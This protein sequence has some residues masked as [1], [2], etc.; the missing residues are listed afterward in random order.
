MEKNLTKTKAWKKLALHYRFF[1]DV[2]MKNLFALDAQR[3]SKY[4]IPLGPLH[5]DYSKNRFN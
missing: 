2:E 5:L 4:T 3:G 1:K